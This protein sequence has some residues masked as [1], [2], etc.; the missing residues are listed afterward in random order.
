MGILRDISAQKKTEE[1]LLRHNREL[2]L[3]SRLSELLQV[4]HTEQETYDVIQNMCEQFFPLD[5]GYLAII[6]DSRTMLDITRTWGGIIPEIGA[7]GIE[8][9]WALRRGKLHVIE[10]PRQVPYAYTFVHQQSTVF[11]CPNQRLR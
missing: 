3:L 2:R 10:P 7:F 11:V 1:T 5:S 8:D 9:C 6:D 4:C